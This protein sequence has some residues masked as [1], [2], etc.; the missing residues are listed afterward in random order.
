[1]APVRNK[2]VHGNNFRRIAA[3]VG[4]IVWHGQL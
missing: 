3:L 4:H 2:K 1:M